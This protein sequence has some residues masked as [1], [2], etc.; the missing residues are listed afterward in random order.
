MAAVSY[1]VTTE[2]GNAVLARLFE[3]FKYTTQAGVI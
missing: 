2:H 1:T 3:R